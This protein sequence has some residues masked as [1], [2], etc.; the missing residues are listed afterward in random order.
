VRRINYRPIAAEYSNDD[1]HKNA[2]MSALTSYNEEWNNSLIHDYVALRAWQEFY[3]KTGRLPAAEE[4]TLESDLAEVREIALE[5]LKS[6]GYEGDFEGRLEQMVQELIRA[7]GSE[8]HV[9]ASLIG[10]IVAQ[11]IVKVGHDCLSRPD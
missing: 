8:L 1:F 2:V 11:E 5:Y 4:D 9:I 3:S 10:G 7:G 6:V